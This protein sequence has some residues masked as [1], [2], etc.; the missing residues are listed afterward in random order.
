M[1]W[2]LVAA[3]VAALAWAARPKSPGSDP[4]FVPKRSLLLLTLALPDD[5]PSKVVEWAAECLTEE[6]GFQVEVRRKRLLVSRSHFQSP[7]GQGNAVTLVEE[8]E[9]LVTPTQ[10]VLGLIDYDLHSPL[11]R[12][13]TFAMGARKGWAGLLST[14]RMEDRVRPDNTLVRLRKMVIRYGAELVCDAAR[15]K[16]PQSVLYETLQSP[17]QLDIMIWPREPR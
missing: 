8:V 9:K 10:A 6:L 4:N 13:L 12:D 2:L 14:Y 15:N 5:P 7:R 17:E 3:F 1:N 11:R 16:N